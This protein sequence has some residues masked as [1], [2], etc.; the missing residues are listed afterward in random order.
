MNYNEAVAYIHSLGRLGSSLGLSRMQAALAVLGNPERTL[1]VVHV[2]GTNGKGS[3]SSIIASI[4]RS[5]GLVT[6]LYTSPYLDSFT[7]RFGLDGRDI[8]AQGV[9]DMVQRIRPIAEEV[10]LT[11]FEFITTLAFA[12]YAEQQV[13]ALVLEVGLG[14]RFDATNVITPAVSVITNIGFDHMEFLGDTLGKIAWEKAGIVKPHVPVT[15][16]VEGSEPY[17]VIADVANSSNA[18]LR[19]LGRD[20]G[21]VAREASLAGQT[22]DYWGLEPILGLELSLLGPHQL[23]NAALAV[24]AALM[25]KGQGW[26]ITPQHITTGVRSA[27]WP[28][29]FEVMPV[30]AT[31]VI[32]DGAHNTHGVAALIAT[33][34]QYLPGR[35]VLLVSGIMKD[36][37]PATM[38][39]GLAPYVRRLYACAPDL[40]RATTPSHLAQIAQRLELSA[41]SYHSVQQ[42]LAAAI[43]EAKHSGEAVLVAGSLYTV[44]E[45]RAALGL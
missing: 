30:G 44:S 8:T 26:Q 45:A 31:T 17:T 35:K 20:Y 12:F 25:L 34:E 37:S 14:G 1:R 38:L 43:D 40:P 28:G 7:N 11:Q 18:P 4:L 19:L 39:M 36:K 42:A 5:S 23:K 9:V 6:G 41:E 27:R 24:D 10:G 22:L 21:Y 16:A 15:T 3:T 13:D 2:A 33:L 32:M 29:R